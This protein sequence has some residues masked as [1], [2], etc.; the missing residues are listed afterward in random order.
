MLRRQWWGLAEQLD[1]S[2]ET[3]SNCRVI[4]YAWGNCNCALILGPV[5]VRFSAVETAEMKML[6][7]KYMR[8][9][10][11]NLPDVAP[12][13]KVDCHAGRCEAEWAGCSGLPW[14]A[15]VE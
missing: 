8:S 6:A 5:G 15:A 9:C 12:S 1:R 14:D 4:E 10:K 2:C 3:A 11:C 7:A 13:T